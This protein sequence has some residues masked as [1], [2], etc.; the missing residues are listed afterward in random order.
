MTRVREDD[1]KPVG[2]A[3]LEPAADRVVHKRQTSVVVAGPGAGKT[4]LLAQRAAFL[5]QTGAC[6]PPRRIL[7]ISFKRDA[8]R[9]LQDRVEK[10]IGA[11]LGRRLDSWTFHAFAKGLLDRLRLGLPE[12]WRPPADYR[13]ETSLASK[14]RD[15]LLSIPDAE[16]S[17]TRDEIETLPRRFFLDH[18]VASRLPLEVPGEAARVA[19][20]AA[21]IFW[22]H[23]LHSRYGAIEFEMIARLAELG[24]R[25]NPLLVRGLRAT[26]PFVFLDE[27][28][29]TTEP[30]Y[31]LVTTGF[32]GSPCELTAVGDPKQRVMKW[33]GAKDSVFENFT[34]E[35][36]AAVEVLEWNF[37][38]APELVRIQ[39]QVA[40]LLDPDIAPAVSSGA[41]AALS[42]ECMVL[43]YEDYEQEAEDLARRIDGWLQSEPIS[44]RDI[45]VLARM[46]PDR[47]TEALVEALR[48]TG[49]QARLEGDFQDLLAEPLTSAVLDVF[50]LAS[51][52]AAPLQWLRVTALYDML[53]DGDKMRARAGQAI[54]DAVACTRAAMA[55]DA[56]TED[57]LQIAVDLFGE[58]KLRGHFPAY[59]D[60][61][62]F[63]E[64]KESL[65]K[66]LDD[67][68]KG[69]DWPAA[70]DQLEGIR[71]IPIL[72]THKSKGLEYEIV[73]FV[74]LEDAAHFN[75]MDEETSTFF[76]ALSRAKR[77]VVF[78][79]SGVRPNNRGQLQEQT[80]T[81]ISALY[82]ALAA[83]GVHPMPGVE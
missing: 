22:Q 59:R 50:R 37:R 71:A 52:K 1:W 17:L 36:G 4:E 2:V 45:C 21:R 5:L 20:I 46:R 74:G 60:G 18:V 82:G 57:L 83:E 35:F 47:Y 73:V 54:A 56:T 55:E 69:R 31:A 12:D 27:F 48:A 41:A 78:T 43:E 63:D 26:Y 10:R 76:V 6:P 51:S 9:N 29:D 32:K 62:F 53:A 66:A 11:E 80:R 8:A 67:C 39:H 25:S 61:S 19:D 33:A 13:L 75:P 34:E 58:P 28:Q 49:H 24:L 15:V 77:R 40:Q 42:G 14:C 79:Y 65:V 30:Q 64:V 16:S 23:A 70:L 3:E 38:S 68:R 81:A 7:A 72:T 44:P